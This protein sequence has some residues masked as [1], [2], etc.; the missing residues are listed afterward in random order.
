M[1]KHNVIT[2]IADKDDHARID[3][4]RRH[5]EKAAPSQMKITRTLAIKT[6]LERGDAERT[7]P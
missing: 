4:E 7:K 3:R 6:L 2:F 5:L 1:T